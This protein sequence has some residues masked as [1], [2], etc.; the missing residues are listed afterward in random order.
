MV[1]VRSGP[2]GQKIFTLG[3]LSGDVMVIQRKL[4]APPRGALVSLYLG[5][6]FYIAY[7]DMSSSQLQHLIQ[8]FSDV[9]PRSTESKHIVQN[10]NNTMIL[11]LNNQFSKES[12]IMAH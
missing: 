9:Q 3:L 2:S 11:F 12:L 7:F 4:V 5:S 1:S 10:L 6:V 8:K